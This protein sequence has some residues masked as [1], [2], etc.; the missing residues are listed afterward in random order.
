MKEATNSYKSLSSIFMY[1]GKYSDDYWHIDY[2]LHDFQYNGKN[3]FFDIRKKATW[4]TGEFDKNGIYLYKGADGKNYYSVINLAQY[5]IGAYEEYLS[6]NSSFWYKQFLKHCYWLV[7]TQA[8]YKHCDGIWINHYPMKT[9][10]LE[11]QWSSALSQA[12]GISAL[13]RAY[14][15]TAKELFLEAAQKAFPAF[16]KS[17]SKGGVLFETKDF[18]CL[19]EY[20]TKENSS[21]LNGYIFAIWAIYDLYFCTKDVKYKNSFDQHI[22]N[23][24]I[25]LS[26][27]DKYNWSSYD[28]WNKHNNISSYFYH[29]LHIKQLTILYQLTHEDTFNDIKNEWDRKRKNIIYS[30]SALLKKIIFR[31]AK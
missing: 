14:M 3:Y 11:N 5:A 4:Y 12:F 28:L 19:E 24:K 1:L 8:T 31:L 15:G 17:I 26:K 9:F 10:G 30:F 27:W 22:E 6:T 23:L 20:P 29:H 13:T 18:I 25:N 2:P 21:V 7:E 16:E